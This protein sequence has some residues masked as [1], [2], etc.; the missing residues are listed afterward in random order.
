MQIGKERLKAIIKKRGK[1]EFREIIIDCIVGGLWGNS[2]WKR[3][4]KLVMCWL[5]VQQKDS[6][7]RVGG[8]VTSDGEFWLEDST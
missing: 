3:E 1:D 5:V 4:P 8:E 2:E 6:M 7:R